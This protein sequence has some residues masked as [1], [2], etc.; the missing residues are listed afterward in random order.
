VSA[1][2]VRVALW[3][4]GTTVATTIWPADVEELS[5]NHR[6]PVRAGGDS[7]GVIELS[8]PPGRALRGADER[9][10]RDLADHAAI[11]FRNA[12]LALRLTRQVQALSLSTQQLEASRRRIIEA[13][14]IERRRLETAIRRD[15][16]PPLLQLGREIASVRSDVSTDRGPSIGSLVDSSN[17][18]LTALRDL[19]RGVFPTQLG[20]L[21][22][23]PSL[24]SLVTRHAGQLEITL[25]ETV[26]SRR[27]AP[28]LESAVYFCCAELV[29]ALDGHLQIA[30][31]LD[32]TDLVVRVG[33]PDV[34]LDG[35][36][37]LVDRVES[38]N[39]LLVAPDGRTVTELRFPAVER[40]PVTTS[41]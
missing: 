16:V 3:D 19:T 10:L 34:R 39:G 24:R 9:L 23:A 36:Q 14:D 13:E 15:V 21:G 11:A 4:S 41:A 32:G 35:M 37:E 17:L 28:R 20:R 38:V 12:A 27:F 22:L 29:R 1:A 33:A 5:P 18:A 7:F 2:G 8:L 31:T 40:A 6:V 26:S 30:L 25:E